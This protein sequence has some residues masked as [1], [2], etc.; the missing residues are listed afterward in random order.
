MYVTDDEAARLALETVQQLAEL[1]QNFELVD[2]AD[3]M[4]GGI[5]NVDKNDA[6]E[7]TGTSLKNIAENK[8]S[9]KLFSIF[10]K[11]STPTP[12]KNQGQSMKPKKSRTITTQVKKLLSSLFEN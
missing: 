9:K 12:I 6:R 2:E 11:S 10:D 3:F 8:A 4:L 1:E 7:E 5:H